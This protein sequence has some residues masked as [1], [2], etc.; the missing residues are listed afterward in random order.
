MNVTLRPDAAQFVEE[1]VRSGEFADA[2][3]VVDGALE[4]LRDLSN[5]TPR[6]IEEL[7]A[8]VAM[9]IEQ[10]DQGRGRPLDTEAIKATAW[11]IS[12][13]QNA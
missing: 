7:R 12:A 10:L 9:G 5:W 8:A 1:M 3:E 13:G 6:D 11:R 2:G 4:L